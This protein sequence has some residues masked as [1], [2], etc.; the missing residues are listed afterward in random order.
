M[1]G[2][3]T[4]MRQAADSASCDPRFLSCLRR[5]SPIV[6]EALHEP[7]STSEGHFGFVV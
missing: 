7:L 5:Q 6:Q 4:V 1:H 2:L 3:A